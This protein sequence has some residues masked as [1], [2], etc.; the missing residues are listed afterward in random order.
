MRTMRRRGGVTIWH[1]VQGTDTLLMSELGSVEGTAALTVVD[2]H[3]AGRARCTRIERPLG[4][5]LILSRL[6]LTELEGLGASVNSRAGE[7]YLTMRIDHVGDA[8][9]STLTYRLVPARWRNHEDGADSDV[10][11]ATWPD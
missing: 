1:E 10:F 2:G 7:D 4:R 5:R 3:C 8:G 9:S 6:L 11:L